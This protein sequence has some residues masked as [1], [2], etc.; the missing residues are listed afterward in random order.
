MI[1]LGGLQRDK[2]GKFIAE[3]I[4]QIRSLFVA[5]FLSLVLIAK[6][7]PLDLS[8]FFCSM[9]GLGLAKQD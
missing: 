1:N 8:I 3:A 6:Q 5:L 7:E 4:L 2:T 9:S